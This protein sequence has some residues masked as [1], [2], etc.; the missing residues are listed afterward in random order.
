MN[1]PRDTKLVDSGDG[2]RAIYIALQGD[3]THL[4]RR[5]IEES[6]VWQAG[7]YTDDEVKMRFHPAPE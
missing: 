1:Y 6:K 5:W 4:I 3:G 2:R 7:F